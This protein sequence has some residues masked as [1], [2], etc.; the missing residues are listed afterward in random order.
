MPSALTATGEVL[1]ADDV[2]YIDGELYIGVDGGGAGHGNPD[3]PSGIYHGLRNGT[4]ELVVDLSAWTRAN[5]VA[6][7]PVD[8][9]PDAGGYSIVAEPSSGTLYVGDPNSGQILNITTD[10]TVTR[11]ADLSDPHMVPTRLA[12]DPDGGVYVGT[13]TPVPFTDGTAQVW[14]IDTD[15]TAEV[16]WTGL[17]AVVDV[18]VGP[19]GSLYALELATGNLTAP[20]FL[21]PMTGALVHQTGPDS[22][23]VV[24]SGLNLPIAMELA[25]GAFYV[26]T[27]AAGANDGSGSIISFPG[28]AA[29]APPDTSMGTEAAAATT[30]APADHGDDGGHR[31][32]GHRRG[33]GDHRGSRRVLPR[34]RHHRPGKRHAAEQ[35]GPDR[36]GGRTDTISRARS[37]RGSGDHGRRPRT[38]GRT[39]S[40]GGSRSF[41]PAG[42]IGRTGQRGGR[43]R[44]DHDP[45]LQ[46]SLPPTC[47]SPPA[48]RSRSPTTTAPPTRSPPT[49]GRSTPARSTRGRAPRS[50]STRRARSRTTATSTRT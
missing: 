9:D 13:L 44:R 19:D 1:G 25:D 41:G 37:V 35:R 22:S 15:G 17:T 27:P 21:Q 45:G 40:V 16:V 8:S 46:R 28:P 29:P 34:L 36:I 18:A 5:P 4:A 48:R 7:V 47:R 33:D 39:G 20:P 31:R 42:T 24:A 10:G 2:A 23:E 30:A 32:H 3:N 14:H 43:R 6:A 26:S 49:T 11:V 38:L 12:L 50:P